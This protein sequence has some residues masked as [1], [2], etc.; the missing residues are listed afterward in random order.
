MPLAVLAALGM[1]AGCRGAEPRFAG[2]VEVFL[3]GHREVA[4]EAAPVPLFEDGSDPLGL[5]LR[6]GPD[7]ETGQ[8]QAR[9]D[10]AGSEA[11]F[12]AP[13]AR[14]GTTVCFE[15]PLPGPAGGAAELCA[16]L[17]DTYDGREQDLPCRRFR[18]ATPESSRRRAA[19][20][21]ELNGILRRSAELSG[22][23]LLERLDRLA[24]RAA[25]EGAPLLGV[26]ARLVAVYF[27]RRDARFDAAHKRLAALPDWLAAPA[28]SPFAGQAAYESAMVALR[29]GELRHAW[30]EMER[31]DG[32]F[33]RVADRKW[34]AV[35]MS[36]ADLLSRVGAVG[37]A[38]VRL[39]AALDDCGA[40]AP[41][42]DWL[43]PY[44][45]GTLAWLILSTPDATEEDLA[46]AAESLGIALDGISAEEDP[47]EHANQQIN[48][49]Y[50]RLRRGAGGWEE[51]LRTARALLASAAESS[52]HNAELSG[53]ATLVE[54]L[55]ALDGDPARAAALC[56]GLGAQS[57]SSELAAWA[58]SCEGRAARLLGDREGARR[59][60]DRALTLYELAGPETLGQR[61][62][63]SPGQRAED[64]Y[65]AARLALERGA[66]SEAWS[67]LARLDGLTL[68]ED[69]RRACRDAMTDPEERARWL[70]DEKRRRDLLAELPALE[71]PGADPQRESVRRM[72]L[73]E[74]REL[75]RSSPGCEPHVREGADAA[76]RYRA[77]AVDDE[78]LLLERHGADVTLA[79]RTTL[80]RGERQRILARLAQAQ[81]RR[82]LPDEDWRTLLAP[83]AE[84]L[85]P[86]GELPPVA[87]FALHGPLQDVPLMALPLPD[88]EWLADRTVVSLRPA[89]A[90]AGVP[91]EAPALFVVDPRRNLPSG[92]ELERAY[93]EL[94]PDAV[95]VAGRAAT[96]KALAAGVGGARWLHLDVHGRYEPAF[97]ELSR[98]ELADGALT[99]IELAELP[100]PAELANLSGCQ[101]GR[102]PTTAGRGEYGIAGVLARRGTRWV[103]AS[104]TDLLDRLAADFNRAFYQALAQP[105]T[106]VA[107]SYARALTVVRARH[108]AAAW[109]ALLL[110]SGGDG[111]ASTSA[112]G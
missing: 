32:L 30:Q 109:S 46:V 111:K 72:V 9:L 4:L 77:F 2:Q 104:R 22:D 31:A 57:G 13:V 101:T 78:V 65:R 29:S 83:F 41:C 51:P 98:L 40:A 88:G 102:W 105:S 60:F 76:L 50:L 14:L 47:V 56:Q 80:G 55:A 52:E 20:E 44:A 107:E 81:A 84:A 112:G 26:R 106:G 94:F 15:R 19:L 12:A 89:G 18:I 63:Q 74:L 38:V 45:R 85:V 49:A 59:A 39:R 6:T 97:P 23:L 7:V 93:R 28:A 10:V 100:P 54:G 67:L 17:R 99:L 25:A 1:L 53:W 75:A 35:S 34:F 95:V 33:R 110:L 11:E 5:C 90:S 79:R 48:L 87:V 21:E 58:A 36:R 24:E 70:A 64:F 69:A 82:D 108:P 62:P 71:T 43:V 103:V 42:Q 3:R 16:R 8:W 66:P 27:A 37:E 86:P 96:R 92:R 68:D 73:E 61:I 91:A